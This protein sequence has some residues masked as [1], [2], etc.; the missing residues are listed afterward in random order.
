MRP[1]GRDRRGRLLRQLRPCARIQRSHNDSRYRTGRASPAGHE[2]TRITFGVDP[3]PSRPRCIAPA[4][5]VP[6]LDPASVVLTDPSVPEEKRFC[7]GSDCGEPVGRRRG[8]E[9]GR[10]EGF[11]RKCGHPFSF[12]PKLAPG[13]VVGGQYAIVGCIAHGGLGWI[14]LALDRRVEDRWVVLKGLLNT[15]DDDAMAAALAERRFLAEVEHP[16]IVKIH[17]FVEHGQDGYIVMEYAGNTSLKDVL[18][19][20]RDDERWRGLADSRDRRRRVRPRDPPGVGPPTRA[21]AAVLR[22]Q[23]R[24]RDAD[25]PLGE[26]DRS[27]RRLSHGRRSESRLGHRRL[28]GARDRAD[29]ADGRVRSLHRRSDARGAVHR[30]RRVPEHLQDQPARARD[31]ARV[32]GVRFAVPRHRARDR[33]CDRRP[34]R[35][36]RSAR[37]SARWRV[38]R[39]Q[40]R[41]RWEAGHG[42]QRELHR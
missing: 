2:L 21:R 22:L 19:R 15:S 7:S 41:A 28:P 38:A 20:R 25:R 3:Q 39:S 4:P 5:P 30:L 1:A 27:R 33:T 10:T 14:Y 34:F 8:D 11:C 29:R 17:N 31:G 35:I 32:R 16:N 40:S 24:Q 42:D 26:V 37:R 12:T 6:G 18:V 36:R 23:A 9:P 13:D